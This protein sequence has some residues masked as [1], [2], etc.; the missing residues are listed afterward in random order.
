MSG[1]KTKGVCSWKIVAWRLRHPKG[2][3]R[4]SRSSWRG[5]GIAYK[6]ALH[7]QD[8][9]DI[10]QN[11]FMRLVEKIGEFDISGRANFRGW[12]ATISARKA[13]DHLRRVKRRETSVDRETLEAVRDEHA[14]NNPRDTLDAAERRRL[15]ELAMAQ[16]PPQQRAI[17][18]LRLSE[19]MDHRE[20][21]E[22]LGIPLGQVRSQ[23][24]RAVAK[25]R[26]ELKIGARPH[27]EGEAPAEPKKP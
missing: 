17:I 19:D 22:C 20:I 5:I 16:L 9:L 11:V 23:S 15:V 8:A 21:A 18:A 13:I 7:E 14:V 12:L 27:R 6:I 25:I 2:I 24:W 26:E 3:K 1:P 4:P 10:T